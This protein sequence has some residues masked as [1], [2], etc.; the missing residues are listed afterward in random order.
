MD[1]HATVSSRKVAILKQ[2]WL[3]C[4][5]FGSLSFFEAMAELVYNCRRE[6]KFFRK[7]NNILDGF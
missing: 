6:K 1:K 3:F 5:N 4:G 7:R 2:S